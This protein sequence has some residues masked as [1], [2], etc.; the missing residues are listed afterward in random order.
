M[1]MM[2]NL[3]CGL[4]DSVDESLDDVVDI[5]EQP[6]DD[7]EGATP[8]TCGRNRSSNLVT[9]GQQFCP[10]SHRGAQN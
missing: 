3:F 5:V 4:A 9:V 2:M 6:D 7:K 8:R 10:L 1:M